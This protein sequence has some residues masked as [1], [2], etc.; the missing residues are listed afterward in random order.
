VRQEST[1]STGKRKA[2][3]PFPVIGGSLPIRIV[4]DRFT[5]PSP[6]VKRS[7]LPEVF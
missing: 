6:M 3:P 2:F 1:L 7:F 4:S 5:P